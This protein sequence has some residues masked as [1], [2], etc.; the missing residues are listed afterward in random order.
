MSSL[1]FRLCFIEFVG[2]FRLFEPFAA[3]LE[4]FR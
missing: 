4:N 1:L 2:N 3:S